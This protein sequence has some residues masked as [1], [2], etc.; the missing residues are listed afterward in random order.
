MKNTANQM[1]KVLR[2]CC[3][4]NIKSRVDCLINS[5]YKII[6]NM[7][8]KDKEV[9]VENKEYEI[10]AVAKKSV[11]GNSFFIPD[12]RVWRNLKET[13]SSGLD[14]IED[15]LQ[16]FL[17]VACCSVAE[18]NLKNLPWHYSIKRCPS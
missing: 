11:Y 14:V 4:L 1:K 5:E 2:L 8:W 7:S 15:N 18:E 3:Q 16:L 9:F 6:F 13:I 17:N 10:I 12:Q